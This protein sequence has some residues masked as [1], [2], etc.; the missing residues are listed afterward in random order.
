MNHAEAIRLSGIKDIAERIGESP[1]E[2]VSAAGDQ[3]VRQDIL[4]MN[5]DAPGAF[6]EKTLNRLKAGEEVPTKELQGYQNLSWAQAVINERLGSE[7]MQAKLGDMAEEAITGKPRGEVFPWRFVHA[8]EAVTLSQKTG[9]DIKPGFSHV[10]DDMAI[11][12]AFKEHGT[13]ETELPR[14]QVPITKDDIAMIPE[15]IK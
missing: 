3:T 1:E 13:A 6:A 11:R 2:I 8:E 7:A 14:G 4:A 12:H 9:L 15:I 5:R 10:I